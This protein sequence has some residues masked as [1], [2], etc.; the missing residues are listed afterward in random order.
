M[1][2]MDAAA[3]ESLSRKLRVALSL[4]EDGVAMMRL[5]LRRR[6][7]TENEAQIASRLHAWL[8]H[9]PGAEHGDADGLPVS[10]PRIRA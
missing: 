3:R 2:I 5:N 8:H 7:P 1:Q 9:R 6:H 4:H 10:W